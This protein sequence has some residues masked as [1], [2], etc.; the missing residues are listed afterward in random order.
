MGGLAITIA[1]TSSFSALVTAQL[2]TTK[3][4]VDQGR[5]DQG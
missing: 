2:E 1:L 3:G 5:V 4:R